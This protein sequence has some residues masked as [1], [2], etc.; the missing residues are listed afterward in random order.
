MILYWSQLTG[1]TFS[2]VYN[3]QV[4]ID[5]EITPFSQ[6]L[7]FY[8]ESAFECIPR[9]PAQ[10]F[11]VLLS[12]NKLNYYINSILILLRLS[13]QHRQHDGVWFRFGSQKTWVQFPC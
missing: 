8:P 7:F 11:T 2:K 3:F 5:D 6:P 13:L 10:I 1:R 4:K 9:A 12:K